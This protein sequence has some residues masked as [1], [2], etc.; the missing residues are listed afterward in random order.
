M[1]MAAAIGR[2]LIDTTYLSGM[3]NFINALEDPTGS[4]ERTISRIIT[5]GIPFSG[6]LRGLAGVDDP[7]LRDPKELLERVEAGLP[8]LSRAVNPLL[9][10]LGEP[11]TRPPSRQGIGALVS[12]IVAEDRI[13]HPVILEDARLVGV[14]GGAAPGETAAYTGISRPADSISGVRLSAD[15]QVLHEQMVGQARNEALSNLLVDPRYVNADDNMKLE[16]WQKAAADSAMAGRKQFGLQIAVDG[17]P[18]GA[19][20]AFA[21]SSGNYEKGETLYVLQEGSALT[22]EIVTLVEGH[23]D[24]D[25]SVDQYL[26]GK[27]LVD[28]YRRAPA[29]IAGDANVW[30]VAK[31][32][33]WV[34]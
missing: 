25:L 32:A 21:N 7:Y 2:A 17:E 28:A 16:L 5:G 22:P 11:V 14:F 15:Q 20:I 9:N 26:H 13:P 33:R 24:D 29:F 19:V 8:G 1:T 30:Q 4:G 12:P 3:S 10:I 34:S 27:E 18:R 31:R 6:F 23:D